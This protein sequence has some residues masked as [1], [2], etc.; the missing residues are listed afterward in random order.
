MNSLEILSSDLS[1]IMFDEASGDFRIRCE[2]QEIKVHKLILSARSPVLKAMLESDT[3][4]KRLG[5]ITME[6]VSMDVLRQ[7]VNYIYTAKIDTNFQQI[8]ELLVLA[9]QYLIEG[10]V[11]DCGSLIIESVNKSNA[12]ELGLFGEEHNSKKLIQ[13]CAE[14]ISDNEMYSLCD[15]SWE[16]LEKSPKL[17]LQIIK[18]LKL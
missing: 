1:K 6:N 14:Y 18:N 7:M 11:E 8:K 9:N 15:D 10:L 12:L 13:F 3:V 16:K 2:D 4:E 17:M 5:V